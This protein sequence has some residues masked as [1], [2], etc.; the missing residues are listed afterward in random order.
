MTR[1]DV[2]QVTTLHNSPV[3]KLAMQSGSNAI[4]CSHSLSTIDETK[5]NDVC[6]EGTNEVSY[7]SEHDPR[8]ILHHDFCI[9]SKALYDVHDNF[10]AS[11]PPSYKGK[12]GLARRIKKM[13]M[14]S[15]NEDFKFPLISIKEDT[16]STRSLSTSASRGID[17][18]IVRTSLNGYQHEDSPISLFEGAI[19][20]R[21]VV[22]RVTGRRRGAK[23]SV[24]KKRIDIGIGYYK[25]SKVLGIHDD[26]V[27]RN[28]VEIINISNH[29]ILIKVCEGARNP[30]SVKSRVHE[31]VCHCGETAVLVDGDKIIFDAYMK[32]PKHVFEIIF[33]ECKQGNGMLD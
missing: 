31:R 21:T 25:R 27:S 23:N 3:L 8:P 28:Q 15:E 9:T 19:L 26:G 5:Q 32:R 24:D 30:I 6:V 2:C 16:E 1:S 22:S 11:S 33:N 17:C 7:M 10:N 20:G 18:F 14:I 13:G 4:Q 29:E 12:M